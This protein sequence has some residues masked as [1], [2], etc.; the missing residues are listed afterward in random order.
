[1]VAESAGREEMVRIHGMKTIIG[2]VCWYHV[3]L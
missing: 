1:M 2:V 3:A